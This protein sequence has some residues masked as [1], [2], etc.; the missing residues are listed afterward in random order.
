MGAGSLPSLLGLQLAVLLQQ[1]GGQVK[2][3]CWENCVDKAG[4]CL[5]TRATP[6]RVTIITVL[7]ANASTHDH[8]FLP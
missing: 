4:C 7:R 3:R 6:K 1:L 2:E 5:V 8:I